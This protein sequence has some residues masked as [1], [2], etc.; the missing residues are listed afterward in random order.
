MSLR[1]KDKINPFFEV[2]ARWMKVKHYICS[3]LG[4]NG[5]H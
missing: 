5:V 3:P 1:V 4:K 2:F